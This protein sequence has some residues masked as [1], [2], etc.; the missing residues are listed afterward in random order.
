M[1]ANYG[2]IPNLPMNG[3]LGR[4]ASARPLSLPQDTR[5]RNFKTRSRCRCIR[6]FPV[7]CVRIWKWFAK[8]SEYSRFGG[9]PGFYS[10]ASLWGV[11]RKA[12]EG[13]QYRR[14]QGLPLRGGRNPAMGGQMAQK[15]VDLSLSH[16]GRM[17]LEP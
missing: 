14:F 9:K 7:L 1:A 3:P 10:D 13:T 11:S 17:G 16:L 6:S 8:S 15:G 5:F 2:T 12:V 4:C